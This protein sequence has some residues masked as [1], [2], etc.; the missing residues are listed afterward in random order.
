MTGKE[1]LSG[2]SVAASDQASDWEDGGEQEEYKPL[3]AQ[4]A[5]Q[6][7]ER[8]P[9]AS[10]WRV[11]RGQWILMALAGLVSALLFRQADIVVSVLYGGICIALPTALMAYGLTSSP[12]AH[13]LA[14]VFPQMAKVSLAGV[15]FWEGIKVLLALALMG[16]APRLI[17]NLSWLALVAGL[18][19]V[20]KAYWLEF[21]WTSRNKR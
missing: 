7:R 2:A 17:P 4:E 5:Q 19:V 8:Q 15:L 10:P 3:T 13:L 14:V 18:V 6:W 11:V 21:W 20:L 9:Q 16:L 12:M 1:S